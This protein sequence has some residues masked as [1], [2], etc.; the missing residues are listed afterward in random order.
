MKAQDVDTLPIP[1]W[2]LK[3]T[4][5][6]GAIAVALGAFGAHALKDELLNNGNTDVWKTAVFYHLIHSILLVMLSL[7]SDKFNKLAYFF[8]LS[9]VI[10]FSGS[11]YLLCFFDL[12]W[13]GPITPIGGLFLILGWL[14]LSRKFI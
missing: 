8:I 5:A 6:V 9:G 4:S 2:A 3:V 14:A 13:L 1:K 11:L 7:S 10:L 12:V